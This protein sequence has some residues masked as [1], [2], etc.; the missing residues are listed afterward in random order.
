MLHESGKVHDADSFRGDY[1]ID[2]YST[3]NFVV[4]VRDF[5]MSENNFFFCFDKHGGLKTFS[6]A[7]D[8]GAKTPV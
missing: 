3:G 5:C 6:A 2:V 7:D 4:T 1:Y 8:E